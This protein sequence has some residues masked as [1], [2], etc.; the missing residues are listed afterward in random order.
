MIGA[1]RLDKVIAQFLHY[2]QVERG[3]ANNT[4]YSYKRDLTQYILY[5]DK[6]EGLIEL[7]DIRRQHIVHF[8]YELKQ[9]GR[10]ETTIARTMLPL[11][12]CTNSH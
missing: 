6:V 5:M 7:R 9:K 3:L 1:I 11:E 2:I 4:V 10:A 8:L 12:R